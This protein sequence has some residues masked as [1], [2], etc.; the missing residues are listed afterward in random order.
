MI[1]THAVKFYN[2]MGS[3]SQFS[4]LVHETLN[5]DRDLRR[6][7]AVFHQPSHLSAMHAAKK[8]NSRMIRHVAMKKHTAHTCAMGQ[9]Y[10]PPLRVRLGEE[11]V[12]FATNELAKEYETSDRSIAE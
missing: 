8:H 5:M 2:T 12:S 7:N 11:A 6:S 3:Y 10:H 9:A 1:K 4:H